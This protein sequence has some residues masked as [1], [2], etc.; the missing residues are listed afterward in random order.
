MGG[1]SLDRQFATKIIAAHGLWKFRLHD[2][3]VTGRS[4]FDPA[5]VRLD[6]RCP[7]GKWIYGEA[8]RTSSNDPYY[9]DV[10]L[11]HADFHRCAAEVL[12]LALAGRVDEAR[13]LMSAGQP[14]LDVSTRL[15]GLVDDWR[16]GIPHGD[17]AATVDELLGTAIETV[18]QADTASRAADLV[19]SNILA[20]AT[21]TEEMTA[22]IAEVASGANK[23]AHMAGE[24]AEATS[25]AM[26]T[27]ARLMDAAEAIEHVLGL[28]E[29]F[30]KQ[31]NLLSLNAAIEAARVGDAGRGFAVV[32]AEVKNLA[33][34]SG[35][36][37]VDVGR[38][39]VAIREAAAAAAASIEA[40][41]T[42]AHSIA[43][44]QTA[45]AA[46]VEQQSAATNEISKR[47]AEAG[48]AAGE[49]SEIIAAVGLSAHNTEVVLSSGR[50]RVAGRDD[51]LGR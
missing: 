21:A 13:G 31:T 18:A 44:H 3:I 20:V 34:Q 16:A 5:V 28:I 19:S 36:A 48:T 8:L 30:A 7:F 10:K 15:V 14:F 27:V 24:A 41:S 2:A 42:R 32:A 45:I 22:A 9:A 43:D 1:G 17:A 39:V 23:V 50:H 37:T 4:S 6:D 38:K 33:Q 11:L 51:Q 49:I 46:A 29:D 35:S 25:T 47:I 12:A 26:E 40:F